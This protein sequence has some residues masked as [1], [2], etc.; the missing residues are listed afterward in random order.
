MKFGQIVGTL[1]QVAV[2]IALMAGGVYLVLLPML[3][4]HP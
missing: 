4:V 1:F 3:Q 2:A